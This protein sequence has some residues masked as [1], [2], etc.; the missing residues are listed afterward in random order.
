MALTSHRSVFPLTRISSSQ[1]THTPAAA[2]CSNNWNRPE[3]G[4]PAGGDLTVID[5][6]VGAAVAAAAKGLGVHTGV[7]ATAIT[8]VGSHGQTIIHEPAASRPC[9]LQVCNPDTI[10]APTGI[11]VIADYS[12][13]DSESGGRHG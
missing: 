3:P 4:R 8:A 13:A 1:P 6:A 2:H 10:A 5:D 7:G 12:H 11:D 9:S